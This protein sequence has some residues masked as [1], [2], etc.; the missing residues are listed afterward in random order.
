MPIDFEPADPQ[1]AK[2]LTFAQVEAFNAQGFISPLPAL[3]EAAAVASR[4]YFDSLLKAV[5]AMNDRRNAYS[6]MSYHNRC[7]GIYDL[8]LHPK[9]LDYVED[10]LGPDLVCWSSHYFCKLPHDPKRVPWHQDATYWPVRPTRTVTVWLAIDDV[11][12]DNAPMRFLPGTHRLGRVEWE[13]AKGEVALAQEIPDAEAKFTESL[14]EPFD[15]V[16]H[17]GQISLH[18][19]TLV[20][21]SEPNLSDTRRCGLTL[22]YL[23]ASCGAKP[24]AEQVLDNAIVCRG[25]GGQWRRNPRP[26]GDDLSRLHDAYLD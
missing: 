20:H 19:S 24:G 26:A 8:A 4:D 12:P 23:P 10:I 11:T 2:T 25:D 7:K 22:R 17:A 16:M 13:S 9:L 6:I 14:G 18:T 5:R 1:R 3:S 15:N 21:G